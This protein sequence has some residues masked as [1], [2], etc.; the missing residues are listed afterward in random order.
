M[1]GTVIAVENLGKVYKLG[2]ISSRTLRDDVGR[3]LAR[4]G[5][6]GGA[7]TNGT[8]VTRAR[9]EGNLF[10]ALQD[11][12]FEVAHGE[13]LGIIGQNGAGKSTLLKILSRV[14]APTT[15]SVKVKGNVVSLLEVGTGFH[16]DLTGRE[17]IFL[18]G[19][20]LGMSRREILAKFDEIVDFSGVEEFIDTP[21]KRYSS[22]MYVRLAFAVAAHLEPEI[23]IMD[24]VLAV[25]DA[26]FQRKC[27]GKM[28]EAAKQGRTVLFVSHNMVAVQSLCS[29]ALLLVDGRIAANGPSSEV[30]PQYLAS[31]FAEANAERVWSDA[32][33]APGNDLV[34]IT[35]I[36]ATPGS[37]LHDDLI[38]MQSPV[39]VE[40]EYL[41]LQ[42]DKVFHLELHLVNQE[43]V[44]LFY[45]SPGL[46]P[47]A[48]GA[49]R[50]RCTIP[51]DLLNSGGY[52]LKVM[53]VEDESRAVWLDEA[54][55]SFSVEDLVERK[56][57]WMARRPGVIYPPLQWETMKTDSGRGA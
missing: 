2:N 28:G 47:S 29:R 1:T 51:G 57:G 48:P 50:S 54:T 24:E 38:S 44:V 42:A 25:G 41:R 55:T 31:G 15:G 30:V 18:N 19:A 49:Y 10:R 7:A 6:N 46:C 43:E 21:V 14:T 17:N 9:R 8:P 4:I 56:V 27:L 53:L 37:D 45:A 35:A 12:N 13:A 52:R 33:T 5:G 20:I 26:A 16:P 22:G 32:S 39:L 34:R 11:I 40:M 3:M 23:L 36:S